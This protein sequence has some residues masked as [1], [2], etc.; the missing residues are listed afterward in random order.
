M[1]KGED[2]PAILPRWQMRERQV[3]MTRMDEAIFSEALR[4]A[5][6]AIRIREDIETPTPGSVNRDSV[7]ACTSCIVHVDAGGDGAPLG[8]LLVLR[9]RWVFAYP[10]IDASRLAYDLPTLASGTIS[11]T[12]DANDPAD[13]Q[14]PKL[15]R[16]VWRLLE[17][18]ATNRLK[19]GTP[20]TNTLIRGN[21]RLTM[22]EAA[23]KNGWGLWAGHHALEWCAAGGVRR[24][25]DG[26]CRPCDD[27]WPPQNAW[28]RALRRRVEE[29]Y[30]PDFG[31]PPATPSECIIAARG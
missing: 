17:R 20:H 25:L 16:T 2:E 23:P 30:G 29:R 21:D 5:V 6:P 19:L 18:I 31:L 12:W 27:W 4:D 24:M 13:L 28:Y 22:A 8:S 9:S 10:H 26:G 7:A 3:L 11:T 15:Q 1:D 14:K